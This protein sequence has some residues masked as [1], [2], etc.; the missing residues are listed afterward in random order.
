MHS[1]SIP[2]HQMLLIAKL[3]SKELISEFSIW[4]NN[5]TYNIRLGQFLLKKTS[6]FI[7]LNMLSPKQNLRKKRPFR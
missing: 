2:K 1:I 5:R 4:V 6:L 7:R 3:S